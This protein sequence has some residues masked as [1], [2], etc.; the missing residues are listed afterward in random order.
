M[1]WTTA[2]LM[3]MFGVWL[4]VSLLIAT[5]YWANFTAFMSISRFYIGNI[6]VSLFAIFTTFTVFSISLK[7][8][9]ATDSI[10]VMTRKTVILGVI[11]YGLLMLGIL[12]LIDF[13][14]IWVLDLEPV[15]IPTI[16]NALKGAT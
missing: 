8:S 11:L 2:R 3:W 13:F 5:N 4:F 9:T 15:L 7:A 10:L 12:T 1:I 16:F 14:I 6:G